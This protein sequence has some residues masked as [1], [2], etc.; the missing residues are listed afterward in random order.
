MHGDHVEEALKR[1]RPG[2]RVLD[3]GGWACP[4]NR[5]DWV[6]DAQP[7]ETRGYYKTIGMPASQG[8]ERE[9]FTK[10]TW[11]VRDICSRE[12]FPF[13]DKFFDF[14]ICSHTLEDIRD[15]IGVCSEIQRVGKRGYIEVPSRLV[16]TCRGHEDRQIAGLSH[17][18]WLIEI[19]GNRIRFMPKFHCIHSRWRYSFPPSFMKRLT[20]LEKIAFL[21]WE[22]S[23]DFE[24]VVI[25]KG[26]EVL[27]NLDTFVRSRGAH[28]DWRYALD[29]AVLAIDDYSGRIRR[30]LLG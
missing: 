16:E 6:L 26:S 13:P 11:V 29:P 7:W 12:P 21:W 5:A 4:F 22:G 23:F 8:G 1:I 25:V 9:F 14:V 30:R 19:A 2:D 10:E 28:P 15:P 20:P 18:R 24:E 17:H 27:E 3:I